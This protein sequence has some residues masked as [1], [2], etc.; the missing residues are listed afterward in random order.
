[1]F[2][3]FGTSFLVIRRPYD[4]EP[5]SLD[6]EKSKIRYKIGK[7]TWEVVMKNLGIDVEEIKKKNPFYQNSFR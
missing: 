7:D 1:M 2:V 3:I 6:V 4:F 5:T